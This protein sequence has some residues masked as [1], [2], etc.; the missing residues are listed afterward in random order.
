[1]TKL[2]SKKNIDDT[3]AT[4]KHKLKEVLSC[5]VGPKRPEDEALI[6]ECLQQLGF[7]KVRVSTRRKLHGLLA[8]FLL[9]AT[10]LE[11]RRVKYGEAL[12]IGWP[13][14][15]EYWQ[16]RSEV[17]YKIARRLRDA[18]VQG[19]WITYELEAQI[20]LGD[21]D[22][23]CSGYLIRDDIPT[24][25]QSMQ[26]ISSD[27]VAEIRIGKEKAKKGKGKAP[28]KAPSAHL[29]IATTQAG[30]RIRAIWKGWEQH[31]YVVG[32]VTMTNAQRVFNNDEMTRGGRFYGA[33]TNMKKELR[34]NGKIDGMAVA[35][36]DVRAM[37]LTLLSAMSGE[38]SF[39]REFEDPYQ[40]GWNDRAQ[41]KA[42]LN[43]MIGAGYHMRW[44][45]G[46]MS[47]EAGLTKESIKALRDNFVHPTFPCLK[48]L[49]KGVTDSQSL[50]YHESEIMLLVVEKLSV[51]V[52]I[53]HD[54]LICRAKDS[55]LVGSTLQ[56]VFSSYCKDKGW[57]VV[58]P[59]YTIEQAGKEKKSITGRVA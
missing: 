43:E 31:P 49:K 38:P 37:N 35:E 17:G 18:L 48:L 24:I 20:N 57:A 47:R 46:D 54:C 16:D 25:G 14:A 39:P 9:Q 15:K 5:R 52:Y 23:N 36:V 50:A 41:V 40:C 59:A 26:F 55:G 6:D 33:W 42:Y 11:G 30:S 34:L 2:L 51:P 45:A 28:V 21:G 4:H 8:S 10:R 44:E 3:F 53:L 12:I 22:G 1:M 13:H 56:E 7:T 19:G 32:S 27:L 58:V 29:K